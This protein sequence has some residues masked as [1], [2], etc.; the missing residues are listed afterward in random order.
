MNPFIQKTITIILS[1]SLFVPSTLPAFA[2][3]ERANSPVSSS[4]AGGIL[5][6]NREVNPANQETRINNLKNRANQEITRRITSLNNLVI[7]INGLKK[8]SDSQKA[9]LT[10]QVQTEITNLQTLQTKIQADSDFSTLR[11]DVDSIIL[12]Y[13]VYALFIPEIS[14]I[15]SADRMQDVATNMGSIAA[16]LQTRITVAQA[17]GQNT[18]DL[19]ALLTDMQA[20]I[21]DA[22]IQAQTAI[23]TVISLTPS[24]YPGNKATLQSARALIQTGHRDLVVASQDAR[25][26][27]QGLHTYKL[28]KTKKNGASPNA[29]TNTQSTPSSSSAQ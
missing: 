7:R 11:A 16:K 18:T 24:G 17:A 27:V 1:L 5:K 2:Q 29:T 20:K 15:S 4:S 28:S 3:K 19:Q 6:P 8:L 13:R 12:S 23:S 21:Q 9:G 14:L 26:I 25:K 10:S 22:N